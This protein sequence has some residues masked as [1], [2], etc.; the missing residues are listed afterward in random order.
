MLEQFDLSG[1]VALVTG[2]NGGIGQGIAVGLAKA[3]A[4]I[5]IA[6]RNEAKTAAAVREI[7]ALGRRCLGIRSDVM[8]RDDMN[9]CVRQ[10]V[11]AFGHLDVLVN[12]AGITR[13]ARPEATSEADWDLVLDT[14]LKSA[15]LFAQAA[16]PFLKENGGGKVIN[17]ASEYSIFGSP[18]VASYSASK[19]GVVQLTKSFAVA[20]ARDNIQVNAILPGWIRTDMTQPMIDN[21]DQYRRII[22]RTP[23]DRFGEPDELAGAAVFLASRASGFVTGQTLAVDGGYSIS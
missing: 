10:S 13:G 17:I 15:F 5:V 2:G 23:A 11:E 22:E 9:S 6:A 8:L 21:A 20:W 19:G 4:D 16:F 12:N 14:N 7:E 3:G 18:R 1:R